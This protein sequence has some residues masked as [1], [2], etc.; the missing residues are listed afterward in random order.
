MDTLHML[1][2]ALHPMIEGCKYDDSSYIFFTKRSKLSNHFESPFTLDGKRYNCGEQYFM[3][4]KARTFE[5]HEAHNRIM[6][7]NSPVAQKAIGRSIKGFN[8]TKWHHVC[9]DLLYPG[10]LA[11][12]VQN[13]NCR[14]ALLH[15]GRRRLGEAT[16]EAPWGTGK[17]LGD[18][19]ALDQ[20]KWTDKNIIGVLLERIRDTLCASIPSY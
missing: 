11:R 18:P 14:Q 2:E 15:T 4:M 9:P 12:F 20:A 6:N 8:A 3:A 17:R 1:P 16:T 13:E 19:D 7:T 5:D 10:L